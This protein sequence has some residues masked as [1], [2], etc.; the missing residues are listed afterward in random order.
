LLP[1][2]K[3]LLF[4]S[5]PKTPSARPALD[6]GG[7]KTSIDFGSKK[8]PIIKKEKEGKAPLTANRTQRSLTMVMGTASQDLVKETKKGGKEEKL[9][10][11]KKK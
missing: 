4:D 10:E 7:K 11:K 1:E 9:G 8:P 5:K 2:S 3:K 6:F